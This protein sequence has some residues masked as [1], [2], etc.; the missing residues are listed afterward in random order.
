LSFTA[1]DGLILFRLSAL[2]TEVEIGIASLPFDSRFPAIFLRRVLGA[3][4]TGE[5]QREKQEKNAE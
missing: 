1:R 3:Y 2:Y 5:S 4:D